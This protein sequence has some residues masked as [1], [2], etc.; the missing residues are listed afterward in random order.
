[1]MSRKEN[2]AGGEL[3]VGALGAAVLAVVAISFF[4]GAP[5]QPAAAEPEPPEIT[6]VAAGDIL[7][8]RRLGAMM[9]QSGDYAYPFSLIADELRAADIAFGNLEGM[10]C[11]APPYPEAGMVFRVRPAA[12]ASLLYA[13]LDVVSVANN[14]AL[15]GGEACLAFTLEHLAAA[16]IAAAGAGLGYDAAHRPAILERGGVRFAFLAYTYAEF[17]DRPGAERA[18]VA[19]RDPASMARDVAAARAL[20]DVV[21]VSLHDGAEYT[22]RVARETE[23]FARAAIDAGAA[24]V[25]GHHPHVA[26]RVEPYNGGW[27]FYSLG[28]FVFHQPFPGTRDAL[29]ARLTFRGPRLARVEALPVFIEDYSRPRRVAAEEAAEMM[30][31]IGLESTLLF[32]ADRLAENPAGRD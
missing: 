26:Q 12:I 29:L 23:Q 21:L 31:A 24:A 14:H 19:G 16:G 32:D 25:L 3:V 7:L 5:P 4:Y 20:A 6:L 15:D 17:N 10:F 11:A 28:N 1:M 13:G 8:G 9:E 22:R 27:I 2:E 18:V 30:A